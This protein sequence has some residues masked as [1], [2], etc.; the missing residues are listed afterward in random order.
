MAGVCVRRRPTVRIQVNLWRQRATNAA[1]G[2]RVVKDDMNFGESLTFAT[3]F[4]E[5]RVVRG[6]GGGYQCH[7]NGDRPISF[8]PDDLA[9]NAPDCSQVLLDGL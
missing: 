6:L 8:D 2:Q 9:G 4:P 7:I 1:C 5:R 3:T